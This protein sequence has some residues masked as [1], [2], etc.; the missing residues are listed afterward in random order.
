LKLCLGSP[1]G[2]TRLS[3]V[4]LWIVAKNRPI[5]RLCLPIPG[6][7]LSL[8][9]GASEESGFHVEARNLPAER[10]DGIVFPGGEDLEWY[11]P[12]DTT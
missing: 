1:P 10:F 4:P 7:T 8:A 6:A 9:S 12:R 11:P 5:R 3:K 2:N